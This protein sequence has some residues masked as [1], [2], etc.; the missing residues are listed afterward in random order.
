MIGNVGKLISALNLPG[1][2][3]GVTGRLANLTDPRLQFNAVLAATIANANKKP[4]FNLELEINDL[5]TRLGN[6][7]QAQQPAGR[8]PGMG[9]MSQLSNMLG[10]IQQ[11]VS[12]LSLAIIKNLAR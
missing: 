9:Q 5:W 11:E 12:N 7:R 2:D 1:I 4:N 3:A 10:N 8:M 6:L